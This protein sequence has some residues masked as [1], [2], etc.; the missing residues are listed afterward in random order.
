MSR[1]YNA[2][3]YTTAACCSYPRFP[4]GL[5]ASRVLLIVLIITVEVDCSSIG[6]IWT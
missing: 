4:G 6:A 1:L 5:T 3:S 2:M